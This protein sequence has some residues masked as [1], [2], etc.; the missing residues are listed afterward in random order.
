MPKMR[1]FENK[2]NC[3]NDILYV[4][5]RKTNCNHEELKF[6][7]RSLAKYAS[8]YNKVYLVG[9]CPSF[10]NKKEVIHIEEDF[11]FYKER[12]I[13]ECIKLA[14]T[15]YISDDFIYFNDDF[16]LNTYF[17]F[18]HLQ[19]Y[20]RPYDLFDYVY[21]PRRKHLR[22]KVYTKTIKQTYEALIE[23]SYPFLTYDIHMPMKFNKELFPKAMDLFNWDDPNKLGL[24]YR[25]L[26]GNV[27]QLEPT[28]VRDLKLVRE[29]TVKHVEYL[30]KDRVF[31]STD[32]FSVHS[33]IRMY[34]DREFPSKCI[35]EI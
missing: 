22:D 15:T 34:L 25:S 12:N 3:M 10:V 18:N 19:N 35:F 32:N 1:K 17:D 28:V 24:T 11:N 31:W 2:T 29:S 30:L 16:F 14:C 4:A 9:Y 26:Y 20:T 23:K 8:N 13:M 7:L 27:Y 6:S 5:G 21:S 33:K